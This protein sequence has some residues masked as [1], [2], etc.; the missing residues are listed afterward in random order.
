MKKLFQEKDIKSFKGTDGEV[1][2]GYGMRI[3][4]N[5]I[6]SIMGKFTIKSS[7]VEESPLH[8]GTQIYIQLNKINEK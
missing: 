7:T 8:Y 4:L 1:G 3:A 6:S 5:S 2:S